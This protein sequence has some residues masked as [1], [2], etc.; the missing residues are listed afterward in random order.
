MGTELF[1]T[2]AREAAASSA[3]T[4]DEI[5]ETFFRTPQARRRGHSSFGASEND[6]PENRNAAL[7]SRAAPVA[8]AVL[9]DMEPKVVQSSLR[10]AKRSGQWRYDSARTLAFQSGSGN[11]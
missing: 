11:N 2:L 1:S 10:R 6:A 4:R 9:I 5:H 7:D 3:S 8:R